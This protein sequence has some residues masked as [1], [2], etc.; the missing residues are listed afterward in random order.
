MNSRSFYVPPVPSYLGIS[1]INSL[2]ISCAC[3][4]EAALVATLLLEPLE[5][6]REVSELED[7]GRE[8]E[9]CTSCNVGV[10]FF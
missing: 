4:V 8:S 1:L 3:I 7:S 2:V 9:S 10:H 6:G 5:F